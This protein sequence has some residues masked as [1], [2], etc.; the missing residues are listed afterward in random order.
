LAFNSLH[1]VDAADRSRVAAYRDEHRGIAVV[2]R[3]IFVVWLLEERHRLL[4]CL[5]SP[6]L[7][8][9]A[10]PFRKDLG[11]ATIVFVTGNAA[12]P[13]L[14]SGLIVCLVELICDA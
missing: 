4:R 6:L 1:S 3:R 12:L 5:G 13:E 10:I 11:T 8:L 7:G 9:S 14:Q 2:L